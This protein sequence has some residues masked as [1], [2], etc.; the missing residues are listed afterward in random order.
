[1]ADFKAFQ[2]LRNDVTPERFKPSDLA[3]ATNM[4]LDNSGKLLCRDGYLKKITGA[5]H[6]LWAHDDI[7]LFVQGV[8][9]RRLNADMVSSV[10]LRSDF[11]ANY[12]ASFCH[13]N[14]KVYYSN[15]AQTGIYNNS[16]N[17]T[18][19][20]VPPVFQPLAQPAVG[21]MPAGNYQY[22]MTYVRDDGQE[23]GTGIA[24]QISITTGAID[25]TDLPISSDPSVRYKNIYLTEANGEVLYRAATVSNATTA[26]HYNGGILRTP[27]ETQFLQ[28]APAGQIVSYYNGRMY[29]ANGQ[30]LYYSKAFGYELFDLREHLGFASNITLVAPVQGGMYIGT[31]SAIYYMSGNEPQ[32]FV[33][34]EKANYGAVA[35]TLAYAPAKQVRVA[36]NAQEETIPMWTSKAGICVGLSGGIFINITQDRYGIESAAVG[37]ALFRD[38]GESSQYIVALSH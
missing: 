38:D 21:D 34:V 19:G 24:D 22:A 32:D 6:S 37:A 30:W 3:L 15:G 14:D 36:V 1:M 20:I 13:V 23:S 11:S 33:L 35:G 12:L 7:C 2:G 8:Q 31:E 25:F 27:L 28:H 16:G 9:L 18:W 10:I 26:L 29:V 5:I 17:R 4:D